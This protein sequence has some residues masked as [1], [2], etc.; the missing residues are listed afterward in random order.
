MKQLFAVAYSRVIIHS[1]DVFFNCICIIPDA[2]SERNNAS[3]CIHEIGSE[4]VSFGNASYK[5]D[6]VSVADTIVQSVGE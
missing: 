2:V 1:K 5:Q 3:T 4:N 6:T